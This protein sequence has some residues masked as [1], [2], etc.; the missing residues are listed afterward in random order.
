MPL[1]APLSTMTLTPVL[2]TGT[3]M[4]REQSANAGSAATKGR[5]A[6]NWRK[7]LCTRMVIPRLCTRFRRGCSRH[8]VLAEVAP[9]HEDAHRLHRRA[10]EEGAADAPV[11]WRQVAHCAED[12]AAQQRH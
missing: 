2:E 6:S 4:S 8:M 5:A 12:G 7:K 3:T 10:D 11:A 9:G 1:K